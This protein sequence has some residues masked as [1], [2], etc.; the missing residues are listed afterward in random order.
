MKHD[1]KETVQK[2]VPHTAQSNKICT[3][4]LILGL[5][6][7]IV[8][9]IPSFIFSVVEH[10]GDVRIAG[11]GVTNY[12][13]PVNNAILVFDGMQQ[14]WTTNS[15][16]VVLEFMQFTG[17]APQLQIAP[18][19][20]LLQSGQNPQSAGIYN[21]LAYPMFQNLTYILPNANKNSTILLADG[22]FTLNGNYEFTQ[23]ITLTATEGQIV[24]RSGDGPYSLIL[25]STAPNATIIYSLPVN[26]VNKNTSFVMTDGNQLVNDEKTFTSF[27]T[28]TALDFQIK[29]QPNG[30][31]TYIT[32]S[33]TPGANNVNVNVPYAGVDSNV[34]LD[35]SNQ[36]INGTKTMLQTLWLTG[37]PNLLALQS[38]TTPI[39][40]TMANPT[41]AL[42]Y[43]FIDAKANADI[44]LTQA[45]QT[46]NGYKT[47]VDTLTLFGS[48][49]LALQS[50]S[51]P[52]YITMDNPVAPISYNFIDAKANADIV[53]TQANQ[54]I[55]G[56]KTMVDTLTL[57]ASNLLE[58][59]SDGIPLFI[60]MSNF[61]TS[62]SY[63]FPYAGVNSDIGLTAASQVWTGVNTYIQGIEINT[64]NLKAFDF[65]SGSNKISL[66]Y[67]ASEVPE[68]NYTL[69][70]V[71]YNGYI[72]V[73]SGNET[74]NITRLGSSLWITEPS[75]QIT[76][77]P[78][79]VG[80]WITLNVP[81]PQ[82]TVV[83]NLPDVMKN[84]DIFMTE[85]NQSA[86]GYKTFIETLTLAN[87]LLFWTNQS[88]NSVTVEIATQTVPTVVKI[89][90]ASVLTTSF[91][92]SDTALPQ[93]IYSPFIFIST[94][95]IDSVDP[96]LILQSGG[97]N[98][99]TIDIASMSGNWTYLF[100][101]ALGNDTIALVNAQQTFNNKLLSN[102]EISTT[103]FWVDSTSS[104][105]NLYIDLSGAATLTRTTLVF[106]QQASRSVTF[107]DFTG[108][109]PLLEATQA[110]TGTNTFDLQTIF[111]ASSNQI[112]FWPGGSGNT[113]T[114]NAPSQPVST[115]VSF[116]TIG[117]TSTSFVV[118]ATSSPQTIS[119]PLD[120]TSTLTLSGTTYPL[121]L[122]ASSGHTGSIFLSLANN[123]EYIIP[124]GGNPQSTFI[125]SDV[126]MSGPTLPSQTINTNLIFTDSALFQATSPY[127]FAIWP[128]GTAGTGFF[129]TAATT[130]NPVM[131]NIQDPGTSPVNLLF[132][133]GNGQTISSPFTF[134]STL[135]IDSANPQMKLQPL[136]INYL[137]IATATLS[138]N[139]TYKYPDIM[140]N[141]TFSF[142]EATQS[143][144][145]T[146]T[147]GLQTIFSATS[148]QI[149]FWPGGSGNTTTINAPSQPVTTVVSFPIVGLSATSFVVSATSSSQ[150]IS[151]ALIMTSTL[152]LEGTTYPL[153]LKDAF[154]HAA[155]IFLNLTG[156]WK[157]IIPDAGTT[158]SSFILSDVSASG[159]TL[160]SQT[161]NSNLVFTAGAIFQSVS[162]YQFAIWPGGATNTGY[163][164]T[165]TT[166]AQAVIVNLQDPGTS[167]VNLV[168]S[169]G[170]AQTITSPFTFNSPTKFNADVTM[171]TGNLNVNYPS[172]LVIN[173]H[174]QTFHAALFV[175]SPNC[176]WPNTT[177][178]IFA[179]AVSPAQDVTILLPDPGVANVNLVF[180]QG[181][182]TISGTWTFSSA[183]T[184]S[185]GGTLNGAFTSGGTWIFN[186]VVTHNAKVT[187]NATTS[188]L[189]TATFSATTTFN[190]LATFN[191]G[192]EF[193]T[194][195]ILSN[196]TAVLSTA[197]VIPTLIF[198]QN[199]HSSGNVV[200]NY[201]YV[202]T[203]AQIMIF[204][205]SLTVTAA[206]SNPFCSASASSFGL[207]FGIRLP[208][209]A[210]ATGT[211]QVVG[212]PI[213]VIS[214]GTQQIGLVQSD[215]TGTVCIYLGSNPSGGA[216]PNSGT[217]G[218]D[219]FT[220]MWPLDT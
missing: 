116:P 157:Y 197:G 55:N 201:R 144:I 7:C 133:A 89:P 29:F 170:N 209:Y 153:V 208:H 154:A 62:L 198:N 47:M 165:A 24:I 150:T 72:V 147:F 189:A 93:E 76:F 22:N 88:G 98:Y 66:W 169:A 34:V 185:S 92:L 202:I 136:G 117:L 166:T 111:T 112:Q 115:V 10:N 200:V 139:Y 96:K 143:W 186:N 190:A 63:N 11:Y 160:P 2:L 61:N 203:G 51:T 86:D 31:T 95:T 164:F 138:G 129:F 56:Y 105:K 184:L 41:S 68:R 13:R 135:T 205:D 140:M 142:L 127:Q 108:T 151:S 206:V 82:N 74:Y 52:I 148:N 122:R 45:N 9:V 176:C 187:F 12:P 163:F 1:I 59:N 124:D 87:N 131:V 119:S 81:S 174:W 188:F 182:Y 30:T 6:L 173:G 194:G 158:Q 54:T 178:F 114:I 69:P 37:S 4:T 49:L 20:T 90:N 36:N 104:S 128:S 53:L 217:V 204:V 60:T 26:T 145:G 210:A 134:T 195:S 18:T 207:P 183:I 16:S 33:G 35:Q 99:L 216:F 25:S 28:F 107:Q 103:T 73:T 40:I 8:L 220:L 46:I 179:G 44:V 21:I 109:V 214:G 168:F 84:A 161:I 42:S 125:L 113:T 19:L 65:I 218:W 159:P 85:G 219:A 215:S 15:K 94:V 212:F 48:N 58:L 27:V 167:P 67:E 181:P 102:S 171:A 156:N 39:Y 175:M 123:C 14:S 17:L 137:S 149:E 50:G 100:Q 32:L 43:N 78:N 126:A 177:A 130:A 75:D 71:P 213:N 5:L 152:T 155:S 120:L 192:I 97:T 101:D 211:A 146:N 162:P 193:G 83:Y 38:G 141:G 70:Y 191:S 180:D 199:V 91:V 196:Y 64:P 3:I 110:W 121:V 172:T 57:L 106:K 79:G 80:P 77:Q 23:P 118:S 132:S